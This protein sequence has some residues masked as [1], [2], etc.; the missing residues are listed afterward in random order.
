MGSH[1]GGRKFWA[2]IP[3]V[4]AAWMIG[5]IWMP[6]RDFG[7]EST[8]SR[9]VPPE[10]Q[11]RAEAV[12]RAQF[13]AEGLVQLSSG[14]VVPVE[15]L[16]LENAEAPSLRDA[17]LD[18]ALRMDAQRRLIQD[19]ELRRLFDHLLAGMGE[20]SLD[21]LRA[22]LMAHAVGIGGESL[23]AQAMAAFEQYLDYLRRESQLALLPGADLAARLEALMALR[24]DAFGDEAAE[25]LF[26]EDERYALDALAR[27]GGVETQ[28]EASEVERWQAERSE[29]TEHL[30]ALEQSEQFEQLDLSP[31]QRFDERAALY[32]GDAAARLAALDAERARWQQRMDEWHVQSDAILNNAALDVAARERELQALRERLFDE[33]EQRRVQALDDV[34][35]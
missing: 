1:G 20:V 12:M 33:A 9:R 5:F 14:Q 19:R 27:L 35:P 22:R 30:R 8:D 16:A 31:Q 18:G 34:S 25:A 7:A 28:V 3:V 10:V 21:A 26:G 24:R 15:S 2:L 4:V 32:G 6:E 13:E 11:A 23:A 17:E 29:A